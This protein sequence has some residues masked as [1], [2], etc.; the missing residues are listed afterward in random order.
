[1][2]EE[3]LKEDIMKEKII[4]SEAACICLVPKL[5]PLILNRVISRALYMQ[6]PFNFNQTRGI[7]NSKSSLFPV[8]AAEAAPRLSNPGWWTTACGEKNSEECRLL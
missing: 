2:K 5:C 8:V 6:M 7:S 3:I 1:M 4:I